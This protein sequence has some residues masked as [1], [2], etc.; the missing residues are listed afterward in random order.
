MLVRV[1]TCLE[2]RSEENQFGSSAVFPLA[3]SRESK[4]G[5]AMDSQNLA[6]IFLEGQRSAEIAMEADLKHIVA[7]GHL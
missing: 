7:K 2:R 3:S 1:L 4:H 6:K 5:K